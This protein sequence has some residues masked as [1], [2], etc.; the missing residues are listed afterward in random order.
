VLLIIGSLMILLFVA[1]RK[2][3]KKLNSIPLNE[4]ETIC[5]IDLAGNKL[6][7]SNKKI[8]CVLD[9]VVLAQKMQLSSSSPS[10]I[11][12]WGKNTLHIVKGSPFSGGISDIKALLISKGIK[13][14]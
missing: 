10:L 3:R 6:I 2:Y 7:D 13:T 1:V 5:A 9:E 11:L 14:A 8:L 12:K 4:L